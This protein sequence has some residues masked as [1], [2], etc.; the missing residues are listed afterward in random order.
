MDD[1][2][3]PGEEYTYQWVISEDSGPTPDDPPCLTHI[4]YSYENLTQDFNSGLIGPLLICKKGTLTEDGTQKMFDKQH[5]LLFA[6]FDESKSW[7]QSPSLMYTVNGFVNR[8]MPGNTGATH[9]SAMTV[10]PVS[11]AHWF[12][13]VAYHI[14]WFPMPRSKLSQSCAMIQ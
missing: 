7:S 3:A 10:S 2:V 8:T 14:H 12:C 4:Y 6:V 1:A 13:K 5:V 11:W 9:H